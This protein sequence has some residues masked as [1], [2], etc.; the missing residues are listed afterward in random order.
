MKVSV[1]AVLI[2][3]ALALAL[4]AAIYLFREVGGA[5][6]GTGGFVALLVAY[7]KLKKKE[8]AVNGGKEA[9]ED[10]RNQIL[11]D[12]PNSVVNSLDATARAGIDA[13]KSS[14]VAAG[15]AAGID[16]GLAALH[17]SSGSG[18]DQGGV[19]GGGTGGN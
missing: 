15:V 1:K 11:A 10:A 12:D 17:G 9:G 8:P 6:M 4:L 19:G 13:A 3:V 18:G 16:A 14:G 5:A 7:L 2:L